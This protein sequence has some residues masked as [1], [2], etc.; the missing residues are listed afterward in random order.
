MSCVCVCVDMCKLAFLINYNEPSQSELNCQVPS[1]SHPYRL[2]RPNQFSALG[3]RFPPPSQPPPLT[4]PPPLGHLGWDSERG[5]VLADFTAPGPNI[6]SVCPPNFLR[7]ASCVR[8]VAP[9]CPP[10]TDT[11]VRKELHSPA[12]R[13]RCRLRNQSLHGNEGVVVSRHS[14]RGVVAP[15]SRPWSI[16]IYVHT[17]VHT[18]SFKSVGSPTHFCSEFHYFKCQ[19]WMFCSHYEYTFS[20][21]RK[22]FPTSN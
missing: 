11:D 9:L 6:C 15:G 5:C 2:L 20:V 14:R 13:R 21:Y 1:N 12:R 10:R 4:P 3:L 22:P 18:L 16:C 8:A 17:G 19:L 7:S